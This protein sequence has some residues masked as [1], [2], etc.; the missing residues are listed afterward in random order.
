[1]SA[2]LAA[3]VPYRK[4]LTLVMVMVGAVVMY[5]FWQEAE[6]NRLSLIAAADG[7]CEA[8]GQP[9]RPA[10]VKSPE[11]G[12]ACLDQVRH[13][14]AV[15]D[16]IKDGSIA[17]MLADLERREGKEAADAA[18]A[19]VLSKRTADAVLRMEQADAA[20]EQ[21]Q[22]GGDWAAAVNELGGLRNPE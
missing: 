4:L 17:A 21:D 16:A 18:L 6:R 22:V 19:A 8:G 9:F 5:L 15:Q 1:M 14:R 11:W 7:I 2:I 3:L 10:D 13:L 12:V 20:V